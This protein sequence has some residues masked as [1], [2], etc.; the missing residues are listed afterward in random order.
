M[1]NK[2]K[3]LEMIQSVITR[4]ANNSFLLKGWAVTLVSAMFALSVKES[5]KRFFLIALMALVTMSGM[6]QRHHDDRGGHRQGGR[7]RVECATNQQM[8]MTLQVLD[9]QSF[10][11]KKLEIA[12]LCVTLGHFCTDDLARMA[13]KNPKTHLSKQ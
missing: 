9:Q 2:I 13:E 3:L 4:M 5:D 10:D 12:K 7:H 6:A 11:D 1:D 8:Q